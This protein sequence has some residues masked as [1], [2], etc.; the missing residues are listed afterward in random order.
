MRPRYTPLAGEPFTLNWESVQAQGLKAWW[1]M[2]AN[3]GGLTVREQVIGYYNGTLSSTLGWTGDTF[4]PSPDFTGTPKYIG[5]GINKIRDFLAG[6]PYTVAAWFNCKSNDLTQTILGDMTS[7]GMSRSFGLAT[8]GA[9]ASSVVSSHHGNTLLTH[10]AV[11]TKNVTHHAAV[12]WLGNN[13]TRTI[14]A[15]GVAGTT[16]D[17]PASW[18]S[19]GGLASIGRQGAYNGYYFKG[20][21]IDV[22][23]YNRALSAAEIWQLYDPATR[24]E[25]YRPAEHRVWQIA[26]AAGRKYGPVLQVV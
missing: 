19:A 26:P 1:P 17:T 14:Y 22:R 7:N 9:G 10:N 21:I 15:D 6:G 23:I 18:A 12:T 20:C 8:G 4:G 24:W 11:I 13:L 3:Q 16:T 5:V 2:A 25:L